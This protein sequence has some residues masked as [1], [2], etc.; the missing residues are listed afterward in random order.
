MKILFIS[1]YFYPENFKGND[2]VFD[3]VKKGYE[4]TVLTGKP[5][6]PQGKF[7]KGYSFFN[8]REEII[9]GAKVI[10]VP[11]IPRRDGGGFFLALNYM[12]FIFFSYWAILFR[13][14]EKYDVIFVQQLS[15]ITM[16]LPGL[17]VKRRQKI[18]L[19]MW[20]LDL[21]PESVT[22]NTEIKESH[23]VIRLLN[24]LVKKIYDWTDVILI[25][26]NFFRDSV[27]K[28]CNN[29]SKRIEY[30]PNWAEDVFVNNNFNSPIQIPSLTE[31]FNVMFAGNIGESQGFEAILKA[32]ELTSTE[33]INW[34]LVGDGRKV[35]WIKKEIY[36]KK[37]DNVY[38]MG[39]YSVD[40]MPAF[41]KKADAMLVSLKDEPIFGLTVPAKIQAYMA[42][43]KRILGMLN[44]EG[45]NLINESGCG[46]AVDAEDAESLAIKSIEMRNMSQEEKE[47]ME[48]KSYNYYKDNFVKEKLFSKLESLFQEYK[49]VKN[50]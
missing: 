46:F 26:S 23:F 31:G 20:V 14:K 19:F 6:Y 22:A 37:L 3:F 36:K 43:G 33:N 7:F 40:M 50:V 35:D 47:E 30:F 24:K 4:V 17:W 11:L 16:A 42:S 5:N 44:G 28:K 2:I 12:S 48:I 10:R 38:L 29:P 34:I 49:N 32:A 1:Q 15:P 27:S 8:K 41:F 13:I 9:K 39:R 18:P 25:S 45:Q 21:W